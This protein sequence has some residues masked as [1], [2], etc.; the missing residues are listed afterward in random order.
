M[1][2]NLLEPSKTIEPQFVPFLAETADD[3]VYS[4]FLVSRSA[5][6]VVLK[7]ANGQ[8]VRLAPANLRTIRPQ[9]VSL[10]PEGLLDGL[11]AQEAADLLAFLGSLK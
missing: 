5:D 6:E 2:E 10:M 4:G 1:L 11:G 8:L 3:F 9:T 7:D